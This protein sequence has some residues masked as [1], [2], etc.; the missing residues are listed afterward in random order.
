MLIRMRNT[1]LYRSPFT[2]CFG[3]A[4]RLYVARTR[5]FRPSS[6]QNRTLRSPPPPLPD[7]FFYTSRI[8]IPAVA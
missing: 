7:E 2:N 5:I 4:T 1:V 3:L 8:L 6:T